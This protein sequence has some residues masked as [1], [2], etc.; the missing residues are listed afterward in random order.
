ME[1]F[2]FNNLYGERIFCIKH[3]DSSLHSTWLFIYKTYV[4]TKVGE[5]NVFGDNANMSVSSLSTY[6]FPTFN[7]NGEE[8]KLDIVKYIFLHDCN[9]YFILNVSI[10]TL[11]NI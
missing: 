1:L 7:R 5:W 4:Q 10:I 6:S 3:I 8:F 11:L 2:G 9:M